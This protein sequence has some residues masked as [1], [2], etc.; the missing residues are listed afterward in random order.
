MIAEYDSMLKLMKER[1]SIRRFQQRQVPK[2]FIEMLVE[3]ARWAPTAGNHQNYRLLSITRTETIGILAD[4][5]HQEIHR[6][7]ELIRE[8]FREQVDRYTTNFL[9][10]ARA[11]LLMIPIYRQ[12]PNLLNALCGREIVDEEDSRREAYSSVSAAIMNLL[13][14]AQSLGLGACWMTGPLIAEKTISEIIEVPSG[15]RISALIPI[16]FPDESPPLPGR[17]TAAMLLKQ[18]D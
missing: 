11:P 13:L 15:W 17:K 18:L 12:G 6:I 7:M 10:F 9:I 3:A 14:A 1:R 2:R 4:V 5:V 16:G 8:D